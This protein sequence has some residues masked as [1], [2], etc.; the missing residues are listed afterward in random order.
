M[1]VKIIDSDGN[2]VIPEISPRLKGVPTNMKM[3]ADEGITFEYEL[4]KEDIQPL[5]CQ[6]LDKT[7]SCV[8]YDELAFCEDY[9]GQ[10]TE[11]IAE[12][13][14]TILNVNGLG[15]KTIIRN[16]RAELGL[17]EDSD[18]IDN[19]TNELDLEHL[20]FNMIQALKNN[21]FLSKV[22]DKAK[23][24]GYKEE[25]IPE[26]IYEAIKYMWDIED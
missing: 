8:F 19:G 13:D 11:S 16:K 21:E 23:E 10:W 4:L 26:K 20:N 7:V 2:L 9:K 5:E 14:K 18:F 22:A 17:Y 15:E 1:R 3:S 12:E 24:R 25:D 6:L